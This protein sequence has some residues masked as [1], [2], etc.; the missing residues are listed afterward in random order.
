ME[1]AGL[2][3]VAVRAVLVLVRVV[4][5]VRLV[6]VHRQSLEQLVS[7]FLKCRMFRD[8]AQP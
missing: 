5:V 4:R 7:S 6:P 8:E 1:E 3:A 2:K